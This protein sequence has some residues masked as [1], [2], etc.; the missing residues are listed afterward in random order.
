MT[1]D[2]ITAIS[3]ITNVLSLIQIAYKT[4]TSNSGSKA[5][6]QFQNCII[7]AWKDTA[8]QQ[9]WK[10]NTPV[11]QTLTTLATNSLDIT[12]LTEIVKKEIEPL[13]EADVNCFTL[14]F[15]GRLCK[16]N[17]ELYK[18]LDALYKLT[19]MQYLKG[20]RFKE[21]KG[22]PSYFLTPSAPCWENDT[23]NGIGDFV[24]TLCQKL[25]NNQP[26]ICLTGMGGI[27]KTEI[28]N[29]IY[30]HYVSDKL[31]SPFDHIAMLTYNGSMTDSLMSIDLPNQNNAETIWPSMQKL[32]ADK[33]VLLLID[34][35]RSEQTNQKGAETTVEE[36]K[37][38]KNLF[39]L[40]ATV[41]FASRI[42]FEKFTDEPLKPLS[43]DACIQIFKAECYES[44]E[45]VT[46]SKKDEDILVDIIENCAGCNPLIVKGLGSMANVRAM[47]IA[48]LDEEL[49]NKGFNIRKGRN[50][51]TLQDKINELYSFKDNDLS[52]A[53]KSLLEAFALFPSIPLD[54]KTCVQWLQKDANIDIDDDCYLALNNL[55]KLT[56]L[57]AHKSKQ[58][59]KEN[60]E[61]ETGEFT[62]F[63]FMHQLVKSAVKSQTNIVFDR[64]CFLVEQ[65][66]DT[67]SWSQIETF[68]K[69]HSYIG[70]ADSLAQFF[71]GQHVEKA[72]FASL[73]LWL[74]IYC[75]DTAN[76]PQALQ[77]YFKALAIREKVLGK[78]HPSTATTY[79]N[80]AGVYCRQGVYVE[81]LEWYFKAL[82]IREVVLG[83][84]H[85]DTATTYHNIALVYDSQGEYEKALEWYRKA[86]VIFEKVLG[87][88]HKSTS[89]VRDNI[90]RVLLE[91]D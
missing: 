58:Y 12:Q 64:H 45:N 2:P 37:S 5:N 39:T 48:K 79:G 68:K 14:K 85:P 66:V 74:G 43:T 73:M 61:E 1:A 52:D 62:C 76:Y 77:W 11:P 21:D 56:W 57:T 35:G 17:D 28:L 51:K 63:Y 87:K 7:D 54:Q 72:V 4:Y 78:G 55:S 9:N 86:L 90:R 59:P 69:V 84:E 31:N 89:I 50:A 30:A 8:K 10:K 22:V 6:K 25:Q 82:A 38:F 71:S 33:A 26:H 3:V 41:L 46:L 53:E 16:G 20:G 32:C 40:K 67:M 44:N 49:K 36:D 60:G 27:G 88:D 65:L 15:I 42:V 83:K 75:S 70:Y 47:S 24:E 81:A 80:I 91:T 19:I 18:T 13:S 34:D 29:K 23:L